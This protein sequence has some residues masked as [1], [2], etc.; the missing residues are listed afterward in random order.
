MP[1][2]QLRAEY[3]GRVCKEIVRITRAKTRTYPNFADGSSD[4]SRL[5]AEGIVRRLG[6]A[7][8]EERVSDQRAARLFEC[9][10]RDFVGSAFS[11]LP[12]LRP[13]EW[14]YGVERPLSEYGQFEPLPRSEKAVAG[15]QELATTL[16]TDYIIRPDI[17]ISRMPT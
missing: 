11:L 8:N 7:Q 14:H 3:H 1:I 13:G 2:A 5:I 10:T 9:A 17:V 4:A 16:G 6:C 15:M 12:H